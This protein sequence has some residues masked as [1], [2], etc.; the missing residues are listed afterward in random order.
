MS[1]GA[2]GISVSVAFVAGVASF[3]S[4]CF[5]PVVPV[6]VGYMAGRGK[7]G[8]SGAAVG[9]GPAP[10]PSAAV[11]PGPG[12]AG[13]LAVAQRTAA[14]HRLWAVGN[15][16]AFVAAFSAVFIS[17]WALV[18]LIGW[19]VGDYRDVLRIGGGALLILLGLHTAGL[20][21]L[22]LLDRTLRVGYTPETA[23]APTIRRSVLL[24]L[25]FGAGW[26]PCIGPTLGAI[27][28]LAT[29]SDSILAGVGLL[30]VYSVGLGVPFVI[31]AA[32]VAG[33]TRRLSWFTRHH[34]AVSLVTGGMLIVVGFLMINDLF[35][36]IATALPSIH[37]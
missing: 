26:S 8:P 28:G 23:E 6:F 33:L 32:G 9:P 13:Q 31:A 10:A 17:L 1:A 18:G 24:G 19:V 21:R 29:N 4:P 27:L 12:D 34:R 14:G 3:A 25:A 5:L 35:A 37:V 20:I 16:V 36:R 7:P 15:A 11:G 22:P 2:V 30:A